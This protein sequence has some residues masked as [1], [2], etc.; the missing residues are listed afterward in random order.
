TERGVLPRVLLVADADE[1]RLEEPHHGRQHFLARQARTREIVID[2]AAYPRQRAREG[3][4]APVFR[5][6]AHLAPARVIAILLAS[7]RVAAGGLQVTVVARADPDRLPRRRYRE[8]ADSFQ[9]RGL[10]HHAAAGRDVAKRR[11]RAPAR[12]P[13]QRAIGHIAQPRGSRRLR[14]LQI[15]PSLVSLAVCQGKDPLPVSPSRALP[16]RNPRAVA[17]KTLERRDFGT[18]AAD[19][20]GRWNE[21]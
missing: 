8:R 13:R 12:D 20:N 4:D 21:R 17:E 2:A 10:A 15:V 14:R 6:V 5:L 11:A 16:A 19:E 18:I 3:D 7:P 9:R 1:S